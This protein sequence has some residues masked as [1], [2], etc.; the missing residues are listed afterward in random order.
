MSAGCLYVV[1]T[2]IGNLED[3]TLRA[4]RILKGADLIAAEDTRLTRRLTAHYGIKTP[5]RSYYQYN[6]LRQADKLL[7]L[8]AEGRKIAIVSNAGTP[9]ISDPGSHLVRLALEK[10]IQVVSI[11]GPTALIAALSISGLS[12]TNFVFYG[13]LSPKGGRRKRELKSLEGETRTIIFYEAPHRLLRMMRDVLEVLG[14]RDVVIGREL[15]KK[16]E[17]VL[18][19]RVSELIAVFEERKPRGEFTLILNCKRQ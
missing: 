15:T 19:G 16:F 14:D 5:L 7:R 1:S 18:R 3:I 10:G 4:V 2:P 6:R 8:L 13:W 17:E 9:G 12:G 11:P